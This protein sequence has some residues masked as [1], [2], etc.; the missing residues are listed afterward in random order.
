MPIDKLASPRNQIAELTCSIMQK[1]C[2]NCVLNIFEV[3]IVTTL[4]FLSMENVFIVNISDLKTCSQMHINTCKKYLRSLEQQNF[5]KTVRKRTQK[6]QSRH[7][8]LNW[9]NKAIKKCRETY[10]LFYPEYQTLIKRIN[11]LL[12]N[13]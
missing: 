11:Q 1:Y 4:L 7:I 5:L 8:Q 3:R 13:V 6:N 12:A 9:D 2:P 10:V